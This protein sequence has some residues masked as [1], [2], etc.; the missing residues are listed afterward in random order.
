M[1]HVT[2]LIIK[3]TSTPWQHGSTC[4]ALQLALHL[5]LHWQQE[6]YGISQTLLF[7][8]QL[9]SI[10]KVNTVPY[11]LLF[12]KSQY[13]FYNILKKKKKGPPKRKIMMKEDCS[14]KSGQMPTFLSR[15]TVRHSA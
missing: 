11:L 5:P 10:I 1:F 14:K 12:F 9:I 7:S 8:C 13:G 2:D 15:E 3:G 4:H 6:G